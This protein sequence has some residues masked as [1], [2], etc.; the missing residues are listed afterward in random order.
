VEAIDLPRSCASNSPRARVAAAFRIAGLERFFGARI[1]TFE[2][3]R[4][5][6]PAPD[7]YLEAA[8]RAGVLPEECVVV[9]D[10]VAGVTA[11]ARAGCKVLGFT[12]TTH[13]ADT[14]GEMLAKAGA[15][16]VFAHMDALPP[17]VQAL[18]Q[19]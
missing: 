4:Q 6:K 1:T 13:E 19:A 3:V 17:L 10:S 7:V 15:I 9:E 18:S 14:H 11:A 8:G 5:G 12:G 16:K 2:D